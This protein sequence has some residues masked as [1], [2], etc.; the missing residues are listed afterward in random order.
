VSVT[1]S[2]SGACRLASTSLIIRHVCRCSS[3]TRASLWL[4][5]TSPCTVTLS[6]QHRCIVYYSHSLGGST[7]WTSLVNRLT[8]RHTRART[9]TQTNRQTKPTDLPQPKLLVQE[10]QTLLEHIVGMIAP[11]CVPSG[12]YP[13]LT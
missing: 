3:C 6:W 1:V 2:I 13:P 5:T 10:K 4:V 11:A 8:D 12:R 7:V 9:H